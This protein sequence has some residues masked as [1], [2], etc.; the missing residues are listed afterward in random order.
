YYDAMAV[1]RQFSSKSTSSDRPDIVTRVFRMKLNALLDDIT[2][3][4]IFGTAAASVY[5]VGFQ[6]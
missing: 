5:V 3:N 2:K 6:N 4:R 1:I